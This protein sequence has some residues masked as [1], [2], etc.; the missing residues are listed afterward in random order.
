MGTVDD[1]LSQVRRRHGGTAGGS[2][3]VGRPGLLSF[4]DGLRFGLGFMVAWITMTALTAVIV[5]G[6]MAAG[7]LWLGSRYGVP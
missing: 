1:M 6:L 2:S 3:L 4:G 7:C 5:Y